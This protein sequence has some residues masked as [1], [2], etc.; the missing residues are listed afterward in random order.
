MIAD[1][2]QMIE[3]G[4]LAP[5]AKLPSTAVLM[6]IYEVSQSTV[7]NAMQALAEAGLIETV[8]GGA[9]YVVGGQRAADGSTADL[10]L[11]RRSE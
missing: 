8:A 11:F 10:S 5:G 2:R 1:I 3:D 4:R 6:E 9:R 7:F